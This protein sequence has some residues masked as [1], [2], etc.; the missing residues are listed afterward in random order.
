MVNFDFHHVVLIPT[1]NRPKLLLRLL[2]S[3]K[4]NTEMFKYP[5]DNLTVIVVDDS[6]EGRHSKGNKNVINILRNDLNIIYYDKNKQNKFIGELTHFFT[7]LQSY[8]WDNR[9]N[10]RGFG[11]IRNLCLLIGLY[12]S[13]QNALFTFL[14]DDVILANSTYEMGVKRVKHLFSYFE[15]LDEAFESNKNINFA[16]GGY[17]RD[18][19][20][21]AWI[22]VHLMWS[23]REFFREA[24]KKSPTNSS[25]DV[26]RK[27]IF[28]FPKPWSEVNYVLND[29]NADISMSNFLRILGASCRI[30]KDYGS[31]RLVP[32]IYN[33][34]APLFVMWNA[35]S[36][37]G[38]ITFKKSA[39][40]N[41][42]PYP[43][44]GWRGEDIT[45]DELMEKIV[46]GGAKVNIPVGHFR[47]MG[48][49]R[50]VEVEIAK[51]FVFDFHLSI[52]RHLIQDAGSDRN[53]IARKLT[54][55][56]NL[57]QIGDFSEFPYSWYMK[58]DWQQHFGFENWKKLSREIGNYVESDS[59]F[60]DKKYSK[61]LK[62]IYEFLD[63]VEDPKLI[64]RIKSHIPSPEA[65]FESTKKYGLLIGKWSDLVDAIN[66]KKQA[67][68]KIWIAKTRGYRK[69]KKITKD[70]VMNL[71]REI[72]AFVEFS[73]YAFQ[74]L[75]KLE[76]D[77]GQINDNATKMWIVKEH[78]TILNDID[79]IIEILEKKIEKLITS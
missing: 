27:I 22:V 33:P 36:Q 8:I 55:R 10:R 42:V 2:N 41:G 5:D 43:T 30:M 65:L 28:D 77:I 62:K 46:G 9:T 48:G 72:D 24:I 68:G 21:T 6:S 78:D 56:F 63:Y 64:D 12:E 26:I 57:S 23:L 37:G 4:K 74:E 51:D 59:W 17:T 76:R 38:N 14:D 16:G 15:K 31:Y 50:K 54:R 69:S 32:T 44:G 7:D 47:T 53:E 71:I 70:S 29:I 13:P 39:L 67:D 25:R 45:W 49:K 58:G 19:Y 73:E 66:Q 40:E 34:R 75:D 1:R 35:Y 79:H 61:S 18:T 20:E 60:K 11:G 52:I 3:I